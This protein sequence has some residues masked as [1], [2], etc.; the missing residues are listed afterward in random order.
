V[1][2]WLLDTNIVSAFGPGRRPVPRAQP[3]GSELGPK[4]LYLSTIS[5]AEIEAGIAKLR[6]TGSSPRADIGANGLIASSTTIGIAFWPST[7]LR[8]GSRV[9]SAIQPKLPA[10]PRASPM[11][12]SRRSPRRANWSWSR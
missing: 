1:S 12:Q 10:D 9:C 6:R 8:R 7:S 5:A 4:A 11:S 3:L 2:G